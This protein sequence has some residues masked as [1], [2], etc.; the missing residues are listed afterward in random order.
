[1]LAAAESHGGGVA[2][3]TP[4]ED[5]PPEVRTAVLAAVGGRS[6]SEA[7]SDPPPGPSHDSPALPPDDWVLRSYGL[8]TN[9]Y[10]SLSRGEAVLLR[11]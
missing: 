6:L 3:I 8:A 2:T 1:M 5:A 10:Y 9:Y 7:P 4:G 11:P